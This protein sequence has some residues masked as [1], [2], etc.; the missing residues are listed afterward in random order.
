LVHSRLR[1][2]LG[3]YKWRYALGLSSLLSASFVVMLTPVV[4]REAIDAIDAGTTRGQLA[5]YVAIIFGLA[6]VESV[7]RF[8]ARNTINGTSR[9]VE[10][11]LRND[12]AGH[13]MALDQAYY[14]KAHT[15]DLMA[16]CTNDLQHVRDLA[17]PAT[18]EL[19]RA[20]TMMVIGFI[21]MLSVDVRLALIALAYFPIIAILM[22]RFRQR[23]EQRYREV[24]DQ[25][26]EL[27]NRVQENI[28]GIRAIKAYAQ[29]ESEVATFA[30]EN[31]QLMHLT[32]SWARYMG[33]FWPLM[34]FAAGASVALVLW[35]GGR[36]VVAGRLTIG[37]FVQFNAYLAILSNPLMSLGWTLTM[38]QQG[39]ASLRRVSEVFAAL[40][41]ITDP[42][43][44]Q[45]LPDPRGEIEFRHVSFG[46]FD[47]PVLRDIDLKIPAGSTVALVGG[48]GVGKTTLA[49][50]LV[51]MYD[52][53]RGQVLIDGVD[54]R[55]LPLEELRRMVGF[56]PQ[57]TFLFS[58]SLRN[59]ITLAREDAPAADLDFAV[60]TS[61]LVN[62]LPQLTF[63]LETVLGER[64]VTLS[65]GQKQRTALARAL[66]KAPPIV[67]LDDALSH[68]DTHTEEEILRRLHVFM[69]ARTTILIA[70]RTSTLRSADF[71]VALEDGRI[72]ETG[73]H[74]ELL[75]LN[76]VYARFY[77]RQ[78]L[79]EQIE[80]SADGSTPTR[81]NGDRA[82]GGGA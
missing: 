62:D 8:T 69:K 39:V 43:G 10:Y 20:L 26:G 17:G 1:Y 46:Y 53:G 66:L 55:E 34:I 19:S 59:N 23:V 40:P 44:E 51:R 71:I 25:F 3:R 63:G 54:V 49:N 9:R 15:G 42:D 57:E 32:M 6:A 30:R 80:D 68:V 41:T 36:D 78:L 18:V 21:F 22:S 75:T 47:E 52:P 58:E 2:H 70:H 64:G 28:S 77:Q 60:E 33:A 50:L 16:R 31:R 67:V 27:A 73:T 56:V 74:D 45:H 5:E 48:T 79:V 37:E 38:F 72:A 4:L 13:L 35:F 61:Q 11:A 65:G 12:M 24:Q 81:T 82:N 7:L 76:G 14:I 29:E